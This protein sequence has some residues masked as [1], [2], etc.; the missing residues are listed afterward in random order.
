MKARSINHFERGQDPKIAMDIGAFECD[1]KWKT[2]WDWLERF[3]KGAREW[4][5]HNLRILKISG[6]IYDNIIHLRF[7]LNNRDIFKFDSDYGRNFQFDEA[8]SRVTYK[9]KIYDVDETF[10][11]VGVDTLLPT[12]MRIFLQ[13][14]EGKFSLLE[15]LRFERGQ[16]P[17]VSM[18]IGDKEHQEKERQF[19][20]KCEMNDISNDNYI[21][22]RNGLKQEVRILGFSTFETIFGYVYD[23]GQWCYR[24]WHKDGREWANPGK[25]NISLKVAKK[26]YMHFS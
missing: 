18:G 4:R 8:R 22:T 6:N 23:D 17:R 25:E 10:R 15:S 14:K 13:V 11:E 9:R 5:K 12:I 21:K 19:K 26:A 20:R 3:E 24:S 2:E 16:D 7:E 1:V